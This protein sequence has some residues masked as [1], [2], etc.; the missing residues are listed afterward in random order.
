MSHP[1]HVS[2]EHTRNQHNIRAWLQGALWLGWIA[3]GLNAWL[4]SQM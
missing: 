3:V 4:I 1:I 2:R